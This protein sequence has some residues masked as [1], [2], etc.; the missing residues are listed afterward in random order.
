MEFV[1]AL[2][3]HLWSDFLLCWS[4]HSV[5]SKRVPHHRPYIDDTPSRT[6]FGRRFSDAYIKVRQTQRNFICFIEPARSR[7]PWKVFRKSLSDQKIPLFKDLVN[8]RLLDCRYK[9]VK[10]LHRY[11]EDRHAGCVEWQ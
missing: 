10:I 9:F 4:A 3:N 8:F 11:T 7:M 5:H 2:R 1:E 6:L